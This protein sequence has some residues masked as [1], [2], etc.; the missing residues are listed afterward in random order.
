MMIKIFF[1][2]DGNKNIAT[3]HI[4]RCISYANFFKI[5]GCECV[6][7]TADDEM[8]GLI[9]SK[10]YKAICLCTQYDNLNSEIEIFKTLIK[11]NSPNLV[12][13]DTYFVTEKYLIEITKFVKTLYLDDLNSFDYPVDA[14]LNY[15]VYANNFNYNKNKTLFL[16]TAYTALRDEFIKAKPITINKKIRNI[17]FT[18]GGAD[19]LSIVSSYLKSNNFINENKINYHIIIGNFFS[20]QDKLFIINLSKT[21]KHIFVYENVTNMQE[22]MSKCDLAISAGGS[23]LYEL[24]YLGIPTVGIIIAENQRHNINTFCQKGIMLYGGDNKQDVIKNIPAKLKE[25]TFV[26]RQE[27]HENSLNL[28]CQDKKTNILDFL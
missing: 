19:N 14:I 15:S 11:E 27:L 5:K 8:H 20:E 10:G 1:R 23:T 9:T 16:G 21:N 6:F 22:I 13:I 3:G 28:Y 17:F 18:T 2:V 12:F 7:V 4:M 25:L 24:S 26:K